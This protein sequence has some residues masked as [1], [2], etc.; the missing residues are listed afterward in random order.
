MVRYYHTE[1][2]FPVVCPSSSSMETL[3]FPLDTDSYV[4]VGNV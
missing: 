1:G 4:L 3:N 2:L